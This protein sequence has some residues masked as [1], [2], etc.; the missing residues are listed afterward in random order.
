MSKDVTPDDQLLV[1]RP[2]VKETTH[3]YKTK[4]KQAQRALK[5]LMA[6]VATRILI[7]RV[8]TIAS[9]IAGVAPYYAL[10]QIGSILLAPG[11]INTHALQQQGL[12][13]I[14]AFLTQ[15]SLYFLALSITHFADL[16]LR[17]IIQ[18]KIIATLARAPLSWFSDT[19]HGRVRKA[20]QDD[21]TQIHML[22]AH[23]PVEYTAAATTPVL[24]LIYSFSVNWRLGLLSLATLPIYIGLQ[25]FCMKDMGSKTAEMDDKLADISAVAVELTEGI[26][27]LK[28]FGHTGKVHSRFSAACKAFSTF[29]WDWCGQLI[30]ASSIAVATISTATLMSIIIGCGLFIT[31]LG[32]STVPQVLVC[33]LIALVLPRTLEVLSNTAW[34]YQQSGNAALRIIDILNTEQI[35]YPDTP[36]TQKISPVATPQTVDTNTIDSFV[37]IMKG[38]QASSEAFPSHYLDA[39]TPSTPLGVV[40]FSNVS[41]SYRID[42]ELVTAVSDVSIECKP[43]T[44]TTLVGHSGSG[45]STLATM[46]ARFSD[47]ELGSITIGGKDLQSFSEQELYSTVSF[48]LQ[49]P[50]LQ[51]LSIAE[52]IALSDPDASMQRIRQAAKDAHILQEIDALP[53][54]FDTVLGVDTDLSGGQK[55]RIAIARALLANTPIIILDEATTAT[56]PDCAAHIQAALN[57]LARGRTVLAIGHHLESVMGAHQICILDQGRISALG[58]AEQ[59]A[60]HPYWKQLKGNLV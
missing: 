3:E 43:G 59:L 45:K 32:W 51:K 29:Y 54:G 60:E 35:D 36:I 58:T 28:N 52:L 15:G 41:Y 30:K 49:N 18:D 27:V 31:K 6:P 2:T 25:M 10:T 21:T 12:I 34:S 13:L 20:I 46:L 22:I 38:D 57:R 39:P 44:V 1:T 33:C 16:K 37:D 17:R 55:Q 47:P 50:Y 8:L 4:R 48:V 26:Y 11:E 42:N 14:Y 9:C 19:A 40:E 53:R 56:D 23:A 24:L 7:S 5:E